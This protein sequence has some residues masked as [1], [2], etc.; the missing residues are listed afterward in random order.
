MGQTQSPGIGHNELEVKAAIAQACKDLQK[1]EKQ[2]ESI[3]AQMNEKRK[4]IKAQGVDLDAF[5]ASYR[6]FKMDPDVR[7]EFDRSIALVNEALGIPAQGSLFDDKD[8]DQGEGQIPS[9]LN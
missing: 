9:G 7:A 6:R 3:N 4:A 8:L 1:L 2:R 5:K